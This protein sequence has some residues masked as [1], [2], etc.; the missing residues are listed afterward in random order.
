[1]V[2]AQ[3]ATT[4]RIAPTAKAASGR[5]RAS[6][7]NAVPNGRGMIKQAMRRSR[8]DRSVDDQVMRDKQ[9]EGGDGH[10]PQRD[11]RRER[12]GASEP[13]RANQDEQDLRLR[14]DP[15]HM[16]G[17]VASHRDFVDV[18]E[19]GIVSVLAASIGDEYR[20]VQLGS[21]PRAPR[22]NSGWL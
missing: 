5:V 7:K 1:M 12:I 10:V 8:A 16:F 22:P 19:H 9:S 18:H 20:N 17:E 6:R 3:V 21:A 13:I 11:P 15:A 14:P 4:P 2:I